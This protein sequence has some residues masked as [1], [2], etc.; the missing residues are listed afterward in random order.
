MR[1]LSPDASGQL[2]I[3]ANALTSLRSQARSAPAEAAGKAAGQFEALF[4]QMLMKQM[5]DA[6][7]QDGPLSSDTTKSYTA[8][9]DQQ[10]A[11]QLSNRGIGLRKV[12]EQQLARNLGAA[13]RS[14]DTG[15]SG[16]PDATLKLD[17]MTLQK[18]A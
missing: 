7:P 1:P 16:K 6:L 4:V 14:G 3:D 10:I 9:F 8:M 15:V 18:P 2:A 5:R 11:Q 12:I 13:S 17:P